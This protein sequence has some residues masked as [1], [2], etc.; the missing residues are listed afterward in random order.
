M[1]EMSGEGVGRV[2]MQH[3]E[4]RKAPSIEQS[5]YDPVS[6]AILAAVP[7]TGSGLL[8]RDL[9]DEVAA[10]TSPELWDRASIGWYTTIIKLDLEARGLIRRVPDAVPQRLLRS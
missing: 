7:R 2:Q 3:P 9:T 5:M 4:G 10:R 8:F 6:T 1:P